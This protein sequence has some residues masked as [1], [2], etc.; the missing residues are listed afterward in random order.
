[1]GTPGAGPD[2][3]PSAAHRAATDGAAG[4]GATSAE[5]RVR[6]ARSGSI[7]AIARLLT[8]V[9]NGGTGAA[10]VARALTGEP[11]RAHVVGITG[12]PG[13]GKST[14]T[15]A[16]LRHLR[17]PPA[18]EPR[19][20]AVLAVDPSSPLTGGALLGDRVRMAE[21]TTDAGVF[22]RSLSSRGNLGGLSAGTPGAVDLMSALGFDVVIVE[23]VG[24]GQSEV[25]V[26]NQADTVAVVLAPGMGD[27][28]QAA[29]AGILEIADIL[30]VNKAD[31]EG[32]RT[33]VR[34]LKSM[35]A[36]GRG[37]AGRGPRARADADGS[38][39]DG[40][41]WD[42]PVLATVAET[43]QGVAELADTVERHR[44]HLVASGAI[45]D[46]RLR[47]TSA[48]V[49]SVVMDRLRHALA[50]EAGQAE[51]ARAASYV[52]S[53]SVDAHRA[54]DAVLDWLRNAG[55]AD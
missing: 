36:L 43:G 46:R 49:Q 21:H 3:A 27:A 23:T 24:V 22:I 4:V 40:T 41:C 50:R 28:V 1:M 14:L 35:V 47:R 31:H 11:R 42:V 2:P 44:D 17:N 5:E 6:A 39:T 55:A 30:V 53:G 37:Q 19:R 15:G 52:I 54:A 26:M 16:L 18:G 7:R 29:K 51:L 10:A 12:A 33:A 8:A 20:V 34:E 13:A 9:E 48:A 25:D 45:E 32:A 38:A